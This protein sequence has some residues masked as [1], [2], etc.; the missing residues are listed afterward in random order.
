MLDTRWQESY[1]RKKEPRT[2]PLTL[3]EFEQFASRRARL[4]KAAGIAF[5]YS[6]CLALLTTFGASYGLVVSEFIVALA[7]LPLCLCCLIAMLSFKCPRCGAVPMTRRTS[8][9]TGTLEYGGFVALRPKSCGK[10][11]VL[12]VKPATVGPGESLDPESDGMFE[13]LGPDTP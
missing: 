8:L 1:R 4:W 9:A 13:K 11:E 3:A 12:F 10:C 6:T 5:S 2:G 7:T